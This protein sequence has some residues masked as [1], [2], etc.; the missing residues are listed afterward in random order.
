MWRKARRPSAS[1][2]ALCGVRVQQFVPCAI[3][4]SEAGSAAISSADA[5][6]PRA[7]PA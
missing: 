3:V 4:R 1:I 6:S 2:A 7:E 5:I